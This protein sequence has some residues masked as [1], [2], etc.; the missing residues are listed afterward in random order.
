MEIVSWLTLGLVLVTLISVNSKK[1]PE[2][3]KA[4]E[5][6]VVK[7]VVVNGSLGQHVLK[8]TWI[9]DEG[10]SVKGWRWECSCGTIGASGNADG[11]TS[12]GS[13]E[14]AIDRFKAH[15]KGFREAN[16]DLMQEKYNLLEKEFADY[17]KACYCKDAN[18]D[19]I[20]Y[21]Q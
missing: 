2:A 10:L 17:R 18:D 6:P 11:K 7:T 16:K 14:N 5:A 19:L 15:A 1:K 9:G 4:I 3:S 8:R 21:R 12:L 13:E 20:K